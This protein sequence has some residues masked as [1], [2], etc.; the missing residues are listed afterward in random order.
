MGIKLYG[1]VDGTIAGNE[2]NGNTHTGIYTQDGT[3][4]TAHLLIADNTCLYN[5]TSG[6]WLDNGGATCTVRGNKIA[7]NGDAGIKVL[8]YSNS[9]FTGN[10]CYNQNGQEGIRFDAGSSSRHCTR[11]VVA[12][13]L[14]YDDRGSP[15][16]S[17]GFRD[18]ADASSGTNTV[19]Y[20]RAFGNTNSGQ[21]STQASDTLTG[22]ILN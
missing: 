5:S 10:Q 17:W 12:E 9:A 3:V 1:L 22:N 15:S 2:C 16:Q 20:N 4:T 7:Y 21:L 18:V 11:N 6:I 8:G 19:A 13:N 14:L